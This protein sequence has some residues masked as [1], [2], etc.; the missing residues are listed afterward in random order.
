L[1]TSLRSAA[2]AL[3][4]AAPHIAIA[5]EPVAFFPEAQLR[6]MGARY[7]PAER[8]FQ[9]DSW[10]G[11]GVGLLR[12]S[13]VTL[14]GTADVETVIG[15]ERRAFD[16]NQANY[17]LDVGLKR[18]LRGLE[19]ALVFGHV[20][21][22]AED[23]SKPVAV[24]WNDL[25]IQL[26]GP[27]AKQRAR[28]LVSLGHTTFTSLVTYRFEAVGKIEADVLKRPAWEAYV[29]ARLRG[30]TTER[31]PEFPRDGFVDVNAEGGV[32]LHRGAR[33]LHLFVGYEHRNDVYIEVPGVR[34][35]ALIGFRFGLKDAQP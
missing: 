11:G 6:M 19:A 20:S 34:D 5:A 3:A 18:P 24:D 30:V 35:R 32:R 8:D 1:R 4:L 13:G 12:V 17:H 25:A 27:F 15:N 28:F 16:A 23:R 22:H 26:S 14:Y 10:I 21:R 7:A 2:L 9:W 33:T 29:S 31:T